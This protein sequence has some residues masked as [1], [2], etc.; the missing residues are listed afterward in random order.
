[1]AWQLNGFLILDKN[2][3]QSFCKEFAFL[4]G[5]FPNNSCASKLSYSICNCGHNTQTFTNEQNLKSLGLFPG[6][7]VYEVLSNI[8]S[9]QLSTNSSQCLLATRPSRQQGSPT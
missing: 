7:R 5:S 1:M 9:V 6:F 3:A 2:E 4:D 8:M